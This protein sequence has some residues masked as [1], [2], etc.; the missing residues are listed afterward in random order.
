MVAQ[1]AEEQQALDQVALM[2]LVK[3]IQV[4]EEDLEVGL[5]AEVAEHL[6]QEA[7][8]LMRLQVLQEMVDHQYQVLYL[9]HLTHIAV[10]AVEEIEPHIQHLQVEEQELVEV[11]LDLME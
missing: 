5:L 7:Q 1:V 9:D 2:F 6:V 10:V 3:V 4:A 11:E 8:H